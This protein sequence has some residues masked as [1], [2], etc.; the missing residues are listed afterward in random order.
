[1]QGPVNEFPC[2]LLA[3]RSFGKRLFPR[4][5]FGRKADGA[6]HFVIPQREQSA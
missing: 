5:S 4:P 6:S 2:A 1:M 3:G